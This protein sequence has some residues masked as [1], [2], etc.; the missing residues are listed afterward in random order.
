MLFQLNICSISGASGGKTPRVPL[1]SPHPL[2]PPSRHSPPSLITPSPLSTPSSTSTPRP[3]SSPTNAADECR[4][5]P[6]I[7]RPRYCSPH[8]PHPPTSDRTPT[9][10][11]AR[12]S[13]HARPLSC[14]DLKPGQDPVCDRRAVNPPVACVVYLT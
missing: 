12:P 5:R 8:P 2:P 4:V 6:G 3:I 10:N 11:P 9:P 7:P 14:I 1:G 13:R